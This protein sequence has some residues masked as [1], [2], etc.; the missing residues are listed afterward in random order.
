[1]NIVI[2][3]GR[4]GKDAE[5]RNFDNGGQIAYFSL[6]TTERWKKDGEKKERTDWHTI[7]VGIPVL[8]SLCENYVKKGRELLINGTLKYR[9]YEKDGVKRTIAEVHADRIELIGKAV[10]KVE[11][12][13]SDDLPF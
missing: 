11:V 4:V 9:D 13:P 10:T 1:M 3:N 6:A 7:I 12:E 2:L 5:V 8:V